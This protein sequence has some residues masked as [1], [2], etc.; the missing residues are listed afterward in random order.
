M[1][2]CARN[3]GLTVFQARDKFKAD[4]LL[5]GSGVMPDTLLVDQTSMKFQ[6]DLE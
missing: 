5:A 2:C 4:L 1:E 6:L 3:S